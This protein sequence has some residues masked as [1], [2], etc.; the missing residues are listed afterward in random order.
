MAVIS[1]TAATTVENED[2]PLNEYLAKYGYLLTTSGGWRL[3]ANWLRG[4]QL[5][6]ARQVIEAKYPP[7]QPV[8]KV[9][10]Y[11]REQRRPLPRVQKR[12]A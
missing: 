9:L 6:H 1:L 7:A 5:Q 11:Q 3:L 2:A 10:D 4:D 12:A 8:L